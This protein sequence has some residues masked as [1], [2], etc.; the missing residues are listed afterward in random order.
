ML[1]RSDRIEVEVQDHGSGFDPENLDPV[2]PLTETER[3]G[4]E[5]GFGIPL[6]KILADEI[7]I[8]SADE[9]TT[10]HLVVYVSPPSEEVDIDSS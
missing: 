5:G 1:F 7:K 8:E 2:G 3:L 4:Y 9:G 6:M 10:V